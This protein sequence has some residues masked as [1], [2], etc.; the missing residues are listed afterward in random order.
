M[1]PEARELLVFAPKNNKCNEP[2]R[3]INTVFQIQMQICLHDTLV[4]LKFRT[5]SFTKILRETGCED[6]K[7]VAQNHDQMRAFI[8][9][10]LLF[11]SC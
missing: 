6:E 8:L 5:E 7:W 3:V 4:F 1:L 2:L 11:G 10:V 9:K